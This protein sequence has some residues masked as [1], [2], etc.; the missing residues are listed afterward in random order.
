MGQW[1]QA[2]G[3]CVRVIRGICAALAMDVPQGFCFGVIGGQIVIRDRPG[4]G[5][6]AAMMINM[7]KVAFA[8][9]VQGCTIKYSIAAD[10]IVNI[11]TE[12]SAFAIFPFFLGFVTFLDEDFFGVPVLRLDWHVIAALKN[13]DGFSRWRKA[14]C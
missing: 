14:L 10:I 13:Q 1:G 8:K 3:R 9:P 12:A 7:V 5:N 2:V 6:A 11:G 4:G